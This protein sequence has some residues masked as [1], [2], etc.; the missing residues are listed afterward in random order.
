MNGQ[1]QLTRRRALGTM[2]A[3]CAYPLV[4][5]GNR[6][7]AQG[8]PVQVPAPRGDNV[9]AEAKRLRAARWSPDRAAKYM[10]RFGAIKGCNYVPADAG[11]VWAESLGPMV[12]KELGWAAG[13]GMNSVRI[14][15]SLTLYQQL[16]D[17]LF[18]RIDRFLDMAAR[19]KLTFMPM[20]SV[21]SMRDPAYKPD[22]V[23]PDRLPA[24]AFLPG[25]HG[26]PARPRMG[27]INAR[28][29]LA[30]IKPVARDFIQAILRRY[31]R[32]ERIVC[33]DLFNEPIPVDRPMV[34][35]AFACAREADPSQPLT[36][37]WQGEDLSDVYSFHTYGQ[38]GNA[39]GG[40][41]E[42]LPFDVEL[43]QAVDSGRPLLCTE[44]LARTFGNT[45]EAFLPYFAQHKVGWYIW[46]LCAGTAQH[47]FPWRWP[48]GSPEPKNWFHC[49]LYP[50]GTPYRDHEIE[51][52]RNFRY[53]GAGE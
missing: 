14:F 21:N 3:A 24:P 18:A 30:A 7:R 34:E 27:M 46:G 8:V 12:D 40:E 53:K 17:G 48:V 29:N 6:C 11:S 38:P 15:I 10:A 49:I 22:P 23:P 16:K 33:W 52:I 50:D 19:H 44:C 2:A 32:D 4:S 13:V 45:F 51:L 1:A 36:A 25:V 37:T 43:K 47:H 41:P 28:T 5:E 35:H 26:G 20:L 31:S 9:S 42:L 39:E